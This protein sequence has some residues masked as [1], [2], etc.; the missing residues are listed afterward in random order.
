MRHDD[1]IVEVYHVDIEEK[2]E[3]ADHVKTNDETIVPGHRKKRNIADQGVAS[4]LD[5]K[6]RR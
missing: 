2:L 1:R 5:E 4:R 3:E 6:S